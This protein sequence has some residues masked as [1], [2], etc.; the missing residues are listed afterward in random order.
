MAS[1]F[2]AKFALL[3][4]NQERGG[5]AGAPAK[6]GCSPSPPSEQ[7]HMIP[8][9]CSKA[10]S[11]RRSRSRTHDVQVQEPSQRAG[12]PAEAPA[13]G[14]PTF[15]CGWHSGPMS[16]RPPVGPNTSP[17]SP[18]LGHGKRASKRG[19][20]PTLLSTTQYNADRRSVSE[21]LLC[22]LVIARWQAL[23]TRG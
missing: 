18:P 14:C 15:L 12:C 9:A 23:L 1:H 17:V 13:P 19:T 6:T 2:G 3:Q 10:S 4:R 16:N 11:A 21:G 22:W 8:R 7:L 20:P 5:A